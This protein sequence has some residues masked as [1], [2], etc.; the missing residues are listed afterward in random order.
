[1]PQE[2]LDSLNL[3]DLICSVHRLEESSG[4][5]DQDSCQSN[6][7]DVHLNLLLLVLSLHLLLLPPDPLRT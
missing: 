5:I 6:Q 3:Q 1:M 2:I 7:N 4:S